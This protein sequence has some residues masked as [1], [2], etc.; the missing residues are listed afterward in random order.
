MKTIKNAIIAVVGAV[1]LL[2]P[3]SLG[4]VAHAADEF[5]DVLYC[6]N[7]LEVQ[8]NEPPTCDLKIDK[9]VSIN[10]SA[11][12]EADTSPEAVQAVIGDTVTWKI[13]VSNTSCM[14]QIPVGKATVH[15]VLPSGSVF[16]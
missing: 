6:L 3:L 16:D 15:D 1:S 14:G 9:Q 4:A 8:P 13:T 5:P 7:N 12:A 11:Y 2:A 10:G